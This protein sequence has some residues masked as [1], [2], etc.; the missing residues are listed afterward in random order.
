M[1]LAIYVS[2]A[3]RSLASDFAEDLYKAGQKAERA[4]DT[5]HAYLLYARAAALDPANINYAA[6]KFTLQAATALS[7]HTTDG[8]PDPADSPETEPLPPASAVDLLEARVALPPPR[9][10]A[11]PALKT[12]DIKGDVRTIFEK[13]AD[14]YGLQI[15][16]E[17][18]YQMPPPF[19]F[20]M[21]DV[22][23]EEA[24]RA[25]ETVTN[26]F[27][28]PVNPRLALVVRDT[29]QKRA[30]RAPAM[31]AAMLIPDRLSP[32]EAQEIITAIQ[33]TLEIRRVSVDPTRH[34]VIMRDQATKIAAAQLMFASLSRPRPQIAV[35]VQF[36][37]VDK[38]S[39]LGYGMA[40]PN[41]L[42]IVNFG[43]FMHSTPSISGA[44]ST[45]LRIGGGSTL[46]GLGITNASAF[47]TLA[48]SSA[49]NLLNAQVVSVDGQPATLHVGNRYPIVTNG[50]YG[51]ATG[52]GTTYTPP[53]T[54]NY[55]DLG[56]VFKVTPSVH[57]DG[58]VTLDIDTEFKVLGAASSISGIPI[59]SSRKFTG[60]VRLKEGEWAVLSGL[61]E[62]V[63]S[64]VRSGIPG[65]MQIPWVGRLFSQNN[66]EHDST[67]VLLVLKPH[68][69]ALPP[70]ETVSHPI[71][72]GTEAR[73]ITLF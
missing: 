20:R 57:D 28:V 17:S 21:T 6:R 45:F 29:P 65:L 68:L 54:I 64:D 33:Q 49:V 3:P 51:T 4:G 25:L 58:E 38:T 52:T 72:I 59:I 67:E 22:G 8:L 12:F 34:L 40:L 27:I 15:V 9:L 62:L 10:I 23:Y 1:C 69:T 48:R 5:L 47:A 37:E 30:D 66:I 46:F 32:Q 43:N 53:P 50:Y 36:L 13:V 16:F 26:S 18:D 55:E 39:S 11:S 14:A 73:P 44:F 42:S 60:K 63:D 56:L 70:W 24:L 35:D 31:V 19:T 71:W 61:T 41:Q 7:T 2:T